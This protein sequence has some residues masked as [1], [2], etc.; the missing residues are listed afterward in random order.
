MFTE[1]RHAI[2]PLA[3]RS[4][5]NGD[6]LERAALLTESLARHWVD[7][8]P[9]QLVIVSPE[10][11]VDTTRLGLPTFRNIDLSVQGEGAFF[12]RFSRF[13]ALPGWYRQQI[14]KLLVPAALNLGGYLTLDH[15]V[16]CV[17]DFD[18]ATFIENGRALSRWEP[19]RQHDWWRQAAK[20]VGV[21]YDAAAHGL[22]VT[23]NVLHSELARQALE[24]VGRGVCNW[25]TA[26]A[27]QLVRKIGR[28]PW[29]EYSL[30]TSVAERTGNLFV[31]HVHWDRCYA[32][33]SQLFSQHS[34]I[35]QA[36]D[37]ERRAHLARRNPRAKFVVVQ[38]KAGIPT[39]QVR[40]YCL[41]IDNRSELRR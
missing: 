27:L 28:I 31:Y 16:Y 3:L 39:Q 14:V 4:G 29:T 2:L 24:H 30:Y 17:D 23:P 26:L 25:E 19:K 10:R 33:D 36:S 13:Y 37:F 22:S 21:P 38:G 5:G 7:R 8:R 15:D 34:S 11:D 32:Q 40:E 20:Y 6:E 18:A 12:P 41:T 9:L 1:I 35:W